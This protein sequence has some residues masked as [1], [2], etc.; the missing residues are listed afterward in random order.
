MEEK[1][2]DVAV[3]TDALYV[4]VVGSFTNDERG[5]PTVYSRLFAYTT[6]IQ[7]EITTVKQFIGMR[8][9]L[10]GKEASLNFRMSPASPHS[11]CVWALYV[12]DRRADQYCSYAAEIYKITNF[13]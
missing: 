1:S 10:V 5:V 9:E 7:A 6:M 13:H 8:P 12:G 11:D 2:D 4:A 3:V